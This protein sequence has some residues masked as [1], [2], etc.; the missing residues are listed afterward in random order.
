[1]RQ[2]PYPVPCPSLAVD[3]GSA[4]EIMAWA[5][6]QAVLAPL[7]TRSISAWSSLEHHCGK[8]M[9]SGNQRF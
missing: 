5:S 6:F 7:S 2:I 1:M 9:R 8:Q 3:P 4:F